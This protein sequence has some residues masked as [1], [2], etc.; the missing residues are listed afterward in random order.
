MAKKS[1]GEFEVLL[2]NTQLLS[3]FVIVVILLGVFFTMGYV[4]GRHSGAA[5]VDAVASKEPAL[6]IPS[7]AAPSAAPA[8]SSKAEPTPAEV[9][10]EPAATPTAPATAPVGSMAA[11][12]EARTKPPAR[13]PAPPVAPSAPVAGQTYL[14]VVATNRVDAEGVARVL[15]KNGFSTMVAPSSK[16]GVFRVLVGPLPDAGAIPRTRTDLEKAGFD[17]AIPIKY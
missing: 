4:L 6:Q 3:L 14:Q 12:S 5:S 7:R 13:E 1:D 11:P 16:E 9:A 8:A 15:A 10:S 17:K 2:G